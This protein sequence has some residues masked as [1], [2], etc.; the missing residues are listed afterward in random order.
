MLAQLQGG[1]CAISAAE[2][3]ISPLE[4]PF[5]EV[6]IRLYKT[7]TKINTHDHLKKVKLDSATLEKLAAPAEDCAQAFITSDK[8]GFFAALKEFCQVLESAKLV[9]APTL[10]LMSLW[11]KQSDVYWTRGCGALGADV[12]AA[13]V[14]KGFAP[15][16][17]LEAQLHLV[18]SSSSENSF[19]CLPQVEISSTLAKEEHL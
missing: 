8:D 4:W 19:C 16:Q 11:N 18:W 17:E 7:K 14:E 13:F 3:N 15:S 2:H 6:E 1:L 10:E 12:F 5:P 9:A